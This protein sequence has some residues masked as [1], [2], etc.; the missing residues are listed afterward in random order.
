[1]CVLS[2]PNNHKDTQVASNPK[3]DIPPLNQELITNHLGSLLL[4]WINFNPGMDKYS[5]ALYSA[6]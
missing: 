4:M 2:C 3:Q 6:R 5:R 1:M